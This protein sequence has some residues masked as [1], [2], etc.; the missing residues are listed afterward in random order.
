MD[1]LIYF[2]LLVVSMVLLCSFNCNGLKNVDNFQNFVSAL[3]EKNISFTMLQETF[4]DNDYVEGIED[5]YEGKIYTSNGI[6][7][8][9]GVAI[10]V[11]NLYKDK[12]K[13][14]Y[15]DNNGRFIHI[16]YE[17]EYKL[18][19]FISIYAPNICSE[20]CNFFK[21]IKNYIE[22]LDN[23][24]IGGDFNTSLSNL[25][26][27]YQSK[28]I[29]DEAYLE[30]YDIMNKC[31]VYDVWRCRNKTKRIFSWKRLSNDV[32]Q[33]SRIDYYLISK[34][35]SSNVQNVFYNET[36]LS[37]HTFVIMNFNLCNIERGPGIWVLNNSLLSN[38]EY[39]KRVRDIISEAVECKLYTTEPLVWWDNLKYKIKK[40]SQIFSKNLAKEKRKEFYYIQNKIQ[41]LCAMHADGVNIDITK[42]ENLKLELKNYELEKCKGAVLRSKAIWATEGD[43]NTKFFLNLE[44]Y[45]QESNAVKELINEQNDVISDT[46]SILEME[47]TFYKKLYSCVDVNVDKMEDFLQSVNNEI[48]DD[49]KI[50]CDTEISYDEIIEALV[51]MS[52]NKS[53]GSDGLTT[54]FYCKFYDCLNHIL[55]KIFNTVYVEGKLSRSMRAGILSLIY[56]KKGD[57]RVLKNYRPI[58]LLQ[59][60]YKILA[61]IMANRFKKVL[62]KIISENQTCCIIGR[63][64]SN[65]IANVRDV[66][67]L[68]ES[69]ELEGYVIKI[70]QE[71]AFDRVSHQYI[72]NVLKK[73]GFGDVFIK[74]IMIFYNKINSTVKCN[75]F[76]TKY[77]SIEN[78]IRQ[79]CPIS[80]LL[81]V[82]AA[83]PLQCNIKMNSKISGIQIPN[84]DKEALIF[85]HADD[86]TLTVSNKESV[87]EIFKVFEKYEASS[88]AK[89][90]KQKSEILPIGI[91]TISDTEKIR[92]GLTICEKE[93]LLLGVYIGKDQIVCDNLNWREKVAK[94]KTLL[95]M[96]IQRHLTIQG[97]VHVVSTLLMSR[98]WYTLFVTCIPDWALREIKTA[99]VNF[100]WNNGSHLVKYNTIINEKCNGGLQ[101]PDIVSKIKAFRLKF[102][103]RF[104][105]NDCNVLWKYI[106]KYFLSKIYDMKLGDEIVYMSLPDKAMLCV[107]N[108]YREM[109]KSFNNIREHVIFQ[110]S[111][112][113][114]Y[115]QPL[116]YNPEILHCGKIII[117]HDFIKAGIVQLKDICYEVKTGFLPNKAIVEMICDIDSDCDSND[118]GKRIDVLK[119][120]I[121]EDWTK[122]IQA[123]IH[124]RKNNRTVDINVN[125]DSKILDFKLCTTK[126]LYVMVVEKLYELPICYEKWKEIF[127]IE[128]TELYRIWTIVNFHWKPSK[129][130][131]VDFK[132]A[133]HSIFTNTKLMKM[134]LI[135]YEECE[136]CENEIESITHLFISCEQLVE[137]HQHIQEKIEILFENCN[138]DK[139]TLVV[140]EEI[141]MF[142][143]TNTMK[144]VNVIFLNFMLSIARYCVL[145]RRNLV[146]NGQNNIDLIRL[147]SYTLKHYVVYFYEYLC[148]LKDMRKVFE[149]NFL[150]DN[151][152][153]QETNG[154]IVFNM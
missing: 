124:N 13:L 73:F 1:I 99:C 29:V 142:G 150:S 3:Y 34:D 77:F 43:K 6:N 140:Y 60:D 117:W 105:D 22:K 56:K 130:I 111:I 32:L 88:G 62:P 23:L 138:S 20:K 48:D 92:Y 47:Y 79:G 8:R 14:V 87:G 129:M 143:L 139:M 136:I 70:D 52:K 89:I 112:E 84:S 80:A 26:R 74:W 19:N 66:I 151:T 67:T 10:M 113:N 109:L 35:L 85:Q 148:K 63:D 123:E 133:H 120:A 104:L 57:K 24:I 49:D 41:R 2:C 107:P 64:I 39:V 11:N 141:F 5:M 46:D 100:I 115:D 12:T 17:D 45:K 81:Y 83:E 61:R 44:K 97:R 37:D 25:D 95:N 59:V 58:S 96:W 152:I 153:V 54:E 101:L 40:I 15:S 71:K 106:F 144:G 68:V 42:L 31:N 116:F 147:F 135:D 118:I 131:E 4:W 145:R 27:G 33:Q 9:Q 86:T 16:S 93:I 21:F 75:G 121:P 7:S 76:L 119:S 132:I 28:H 149:K 134:K 98:I 72:F 108:I 102:V 69:D 36:A 53:P 114:I 78:G 90:N 82:L 126:Q 128:E 91:G 127:D 94:I 65:N 103:I 51:N 154:V 146:K 18:Y 137:F 125:R 50:M 30:M 38:E 55:F 122:T 110:H